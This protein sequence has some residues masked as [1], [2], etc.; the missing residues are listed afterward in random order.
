MQVAL[1]MYV[2]NYS[3]QGDMPLAL[4]HVLNRIPENGEL[5]YETDGNPSYFLVNNIL[6][7]LQPFEELSVGNEGINITVQ[8]RIDR[9]LG[10]LD[11]RVCP[12]K[13]SMIY[14]IPGKSLYLTILAYSVYP[15]SSSWRAL[16]SR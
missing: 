2:G 12:T 14:Q 8:S 1:A 9:L 3:I 15:G 6:Q 16:S 4:F 13:S 11:R 7:H 5:R 10:F